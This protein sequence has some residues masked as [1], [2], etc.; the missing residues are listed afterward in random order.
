MKEDINLN[1]KE[2]SNEKYIHIKQNK[3]ETKI[4]DIL[5]QYKKGI[6]SIFEDS[7]FDESEGNYFLLI[8]KC[9]NSFS[10]KYHD[11][12]NETLNQ[13]L[14]LKA[15]SDSENILDLSPQDNFTEEHLNVN[16]KGKNNKYTIMLY[17]IFE[18]FFGMNIYLLD[19]LILHYFEKKINKIFEYEDFILLF[20]SIIKY[21]TDLDISL[22]LSNSSN[23]L[24]IYIFGND[25][26][27]TKI[28]GMLNYNLQLNPIA[29]N[30]EENET[31]KE[32]KESSSENNLKNIEL[33]D[34]DEQEPLL[35]SFNKKIEE[36]NLQFEDYDLNNPIFWPPYIPYKPEKD[37]QF[38]NYELNDDFHYSKNNEIYNETDKRY[39]SKFRNIDKLRFIQRILNQI[40]KFSELKKIEIFE[41]MLF[42]RNNK[43]YNKKL[44]EL[45]VQNTLNP[46]DDKKCARFIN[47]IRN[48]YGETVSYYFL[49]VDH[50]SRMLLFPSILGTF[51]FISYFFWNKIPIV[52][53]FSNSIK[54]D[55]YEFL[56]ILNSALLT[57]WLTLFIKSWLQ[58]EK[59]YNYI[60]GINLKEKEIKI[61][62]EFVPNSKE[63]LIF[64]YY[65]P[66]EK[67]PFHTLKKYVSYCFL[68]GMILL[69]LFFIYS[70]FRLKARL[71]NGN[72]WHDYRITFYI[73]CLNGLQIKV[74]NFIYYYIS[75]FLNDWENHFSMQEKNNSFAMKLILFDFMNS[76]SSL[77]YIAFI[78]PY[79]EGCVN[80]DCPKELE[81]QL[82]SIFLVYISIFFGEILYLYIL[83]Y[84]QK[85]KMR[86][87]INE[88]NIQ[89]Q[90]LE[91]QIMLQPTDNL[92]VE[93][94]DIINQF[95]FACL[96]SIA[97]PLTP[98]II[99]LLS[100]VYRV[101]NYYKFIHLKRVE[102]LDEA[103]GIS[104]YNKIIQMFLFIGVMVNVA[105]FMFSNPNPTMPFSTMETIKSK[106]LSIFIIENSV[107][108]IYYYVDWNI[109]PNWFKYKDI[110]KELYL[111]K[112]L[113]KD[114]KRK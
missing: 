38:R 80:N 35:N 100:L 55:Y 7:K 15:F 78:K 47:T 27:Y 89:I 114:K 53:I 32:K 41:M 67:E 20:C 19:I 59:L 60:W 34:Y 18:K 40:I 109:L 8:F 83:Y 43:S 112:Y 77:F 25:D 13:S 70:L 49:W 24:M 54:M 58:K 71:I 28:C 82:Y 102:I 64:G 90:S 9:P 62:E 1:N 37:S 65:V 72:V 45:S 95:G 93:Y 104:F 99:F 21:Y 76:Y 86:S 75:K 57:I 23:Y 111:N 69:V 85:R 73:A 6:E 105:I 98:L 44:K 101:T 39:I 50:F 26:T 79:N 4:N 22:E 33:I 42:K 96:F 113:Y 2:E 51:I 94:S 63:K 91:H 84:Y 52:T 68:L 17:K 11:L 36:E 106:F 29:I 16:S 30:Y 66:I 110:I 107:I 12:N 74:M 14:Q 48:Y 61:N 81:T 3:T 97:A 46:F 108:L 103:K 56:L 31:N 87:F 10:L 88:E 5:S 92:N